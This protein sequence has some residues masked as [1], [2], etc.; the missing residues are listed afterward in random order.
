[1]VQVLQKTTFTCLYIHLS[2]TLNHYLIMGTTQVFPNV[3]KFG[4]NSTT[5]CWMKVGTSSGP[6]TYPSNSAGCATWS[7]VISCQ[8]PDGNGGFTDNLFI[9]NPDSQSPILTN[10][11]NGNQ[12]ALPAPPWNAVCVVN[13]IIYWTAMYNNGTEWLYGAWSLDP[14]T[15]DNTIT[16]LTGWPTIQFQA[17]AGYYD[18]AQSTTLFALLTDGSCYIMTGGQWSYKNQMPVNGATVT[19]MTNVGSDIYAGLSNGSILKLNQ[20][21][22]SQST[23][24]FSNSQI[25]F[26]SLVGWQLEHNIPVPP[27]YT[28]ILY[29][30]ASGSVGCIYLDMPYNSN[31]PAAAEQ[32]I[33]GNL[34]GSATSLTFANGNLFYL[35]NN[36][37]TNLIQ[38]VDPVAGVYFYVPTPPGSNKFGTVLLPNSNTAVSNNPQSPTPMSI[39]I[40]AGNLQEITLWTIPST[41][42]DYSLQFTYDNEGNQYT[43]AMNFP[44]SEWGNTGI[45]ITVDA[46]L[47]SSGGTEIITLISLDPVKP[48]VKQQ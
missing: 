32:L 29:F 9:F 36:G 42:P 12:W 10:I 1:M 38:Q 4:N 8:L 34:G 23:V 17:M 44:H 16:S 27:V 11:T 28:N 30:I 13:S 14:S 40:A 46:D 31:A 3:R 7:N 26:N 25:S 45:L 43:P 22:P 5:P 6:V 20:S 2:L 47:I 24:V 39:Q 19:C 37:T 41:N 33:A 15:Q 35:I 18:T 48:G 21:D